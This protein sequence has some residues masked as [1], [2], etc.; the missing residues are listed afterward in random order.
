MK[1]QK[2]ASYRYC[3]YVH[4]PSVVGDFS[5]S[6]VGM[7]WNDS[8]FVRQFFVFL[9]CDH[10]HVLQRH[11]DIKFSVFTFCQLWHVL[12]IFDVGSEKGPQKS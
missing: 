9:L 8:V 4:V 6:A 11:Q 2:S 3:D 12:H 5:Q 10:V 1:Q 7:R